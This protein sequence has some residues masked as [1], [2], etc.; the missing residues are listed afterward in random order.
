MFD[1]RLGGLVICIGASIFLAAAFAPMSR[2]FAVRSPDEKLAIINRSPGFWRLFQALFALGAIITALGV[3]LLEFSQY[4][5]FSV[6]QFLPAVLLL[7]G[8]IPWCAH[9]YLR[10]VDP[11]AFAFGTL[12][13]WHFK[14]YTLLTLA[15]FFLLGIELLR[16]MGGTWQG[17]FLMGASMLIYILYQQFKDMPPFVYY[18]LALVLGVSILVN[19]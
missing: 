2:V 6:E 12:P 19:A 11:E 15:A 16:L 9:V 18:L 13:A 14:F 17:F 5:R 4:W 7:I 3:G 1:L 10:A 8:A